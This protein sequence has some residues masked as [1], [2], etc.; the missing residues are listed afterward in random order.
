MFNIEAEWI[1]LLIVGFATLFLV[2]EIL[3]NAKGIFSILGLGFITVY[4]SSFLDVG[5]FFVMILIY[6]IGLLLIVID[7]K[8]LNDGTL[9]VIGTVL[10]IVSVGFAS[11]NWLA[12]TYAVLGVLIGGISSLFF[13]KV[14]KKRN[15]WTKMTLFDQLTDEAGYSSINQTYKSLVGKTGM[16]Q[17]DMRPIGT[18][19]IEDQEYSA[20]TQGKWLKKD[21][22][23]KVESVDGTRILV[24]E[25]S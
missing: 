3:V 23:I 18:V 21:T 8:V 20:I 4:F 11:P 15:M 16:T 10:M 19:I 9:A 25:R 7:G 17:T 2:G 5:M 13:L 1:S 6:F 14:F 12:G 22:E 24:K